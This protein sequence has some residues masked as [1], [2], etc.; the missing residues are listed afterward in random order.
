MEFTRTAQATTQR[1]FVADQTFTIRSAGSGTYEV[2]NALRARNFG[3]GDKTEDISVPDYFPHIGY[4]LSSG[5]SFDYL[6]LAK[7]PNATPA[8]VTFYGGYG[9][10]QHNDPVVDGTR[11]RLDYFVYG[12][13]TPPASMP[14]T[15]RVTFRV[16]GTGNFAADD[17]L[18]FAFHD[19][20][21]TVDF[22]AGTVTANL[23]LSGTGDFFNGGFAGVNAGRIVGSIV[24]SGA[25]GDLASSIATARGR[26]A[27]V[28]FGP[29]AEEIGLAYSG[30]FERQT[31]AAA[32]VGIRDARF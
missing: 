13:Q 28:F 8:V 27:I 2:V 3:S 5:T 12:T 10:W 18:S 29:N 25:K 21:V 15:G 17:A 4:R 26:Y 30:A 9:A 16:P 22:A 11:I 23:T 32:G 31:W 20:F 7:P 24:G 19:T 14:R 1:S 6:L